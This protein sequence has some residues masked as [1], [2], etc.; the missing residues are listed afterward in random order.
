MAEDDIIVL[1]R[2]PAAALLALAFLI[3]GRQILMNALTA[4]PFGVGTLSHPSLGFSDEELLALI[5]LLTGLR[6]DIE[7]TLIGWD[8][9]A[10]FLMLLREPAI[11]RIPEAQRSD[12]EEWVALARY[13]LDFPPEEQVD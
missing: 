6:P 11:Q 7:Y 5:F 3:G 9:F 12:P 2:W 10:A 1:G 8:E 13:L 4:R